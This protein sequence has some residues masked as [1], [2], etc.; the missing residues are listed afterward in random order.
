MITHASLILPEL[1]AV[2]R[3]GD[4]GLSGWQCMQCVHESALHGLLYIGYL[5]YL[6]GPSVG[7]T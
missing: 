7:L 4:G 6:D 3:I 5:P 2:V 1:P